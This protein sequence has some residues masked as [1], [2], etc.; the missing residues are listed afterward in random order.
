MWKLTCLLAFALAAA[1]ICS[2]QARHPERTANPETTKKATVVNPFAGKWTYRSY[3]NRPDI[4]DQD[5][6]LALKMIF[7]EGVITVENSDLKMFKG[8]FDMGGGFVLDME[9][10]VRWQTYV[11][12]TIFEISGKGRAGTPTEGWQ[13]DYVG[14]LA[15]EWPNGIG[16]VPAIVGTVIRTKPHGASKAGYVASFV[17]IKQP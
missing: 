13:Y 8:S 1:G 7:G 6:A 5:A 12:P 2:A 11:S 10:T 16:Q 17:A 9:G 14:Y 3:H 4:V 15:W